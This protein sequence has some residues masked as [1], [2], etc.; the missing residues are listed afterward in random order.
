MLS[1]C[2]NKLINEDYNCPYFIDKMCQLIKV[3]QLAHGPIASKGQ[4]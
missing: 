4:S 2:I 1:N 3:K